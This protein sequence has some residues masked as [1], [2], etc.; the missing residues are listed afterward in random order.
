LMIQYIEF[1]VD[2]WLVEFGYSK[3][4]RSKN[5]FD[6]MEYLSLESKTNFFE[7]GVSSYS[8]AG[9]GMTEKQ[10]TFSTEEDF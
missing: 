10:M 5:P 9:A 3:L 8:K 4:F 7:K 6:F 1:I 2:Y